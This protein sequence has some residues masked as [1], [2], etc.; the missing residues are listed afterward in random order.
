MESSVAKL[1]NNSI[2]IER[3]EKQQHVRTKIVYDNFVFICLT[4]YKMF[5]QMKY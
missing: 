5:K 2:N 4:D 3:E 1:T